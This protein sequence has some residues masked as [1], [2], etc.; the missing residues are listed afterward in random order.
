MFVLFV[1]F[2]C[3]VCLFV[4]TR[5]D[6]IGGRCCWRWFDLTASSSFSKTMS[7]FAYFFTCSGGGGKPITTQ[8]SHDRKTFLS[9][10]FLLPLFFCFV[11]SLPPLYPQRIP[12]TFSTK[13]F[14]SFN[15]SA[16][17]SPLRGSEG[18][19]YISS[20]GRNT[21]N[22]LTK[23]NIGLQVWFNTSTHTEPE[24]WLQFETE[25]VMRRMKT[26]QTEATWI[27]PLPFIHIGVIDGVAKTDRR[28]LVRVIG[29]KSHMNFPLASVIRTYEFGN[30]FRWWAP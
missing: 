14:L 10:S 13:D 21:V 20:W 28:G 1:L 9:I 27:E 24:L 2:V 30:R 18:L 7:S 3:V 15:M 25:S 5:F 17:A 22:T 26:K 8:V 19:G 29:W 6:F 11:R 4:T 23:S 12:R 16:A